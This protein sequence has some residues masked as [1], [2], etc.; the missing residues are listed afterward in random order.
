[1]PAG[2][3]VPPAAALL[4]TL[5]SL[6]HH[7]SSLLPPHAAGPNLLPAV[8]PQASGAP[9][10]H[11]PHP[12]CPSISR[13]QGGAVAPLPQVAGSGSST[14][15]GPLKQLCDGWAAAGAAGERHVFTAGPTDQATGAVHE[16]IV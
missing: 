6:S 9:H 16:M 12:G 7:N 2:P 11:W 15:Q 13:L 5:F 10:S 1:M 3:N 14:Q 8:P 4:G